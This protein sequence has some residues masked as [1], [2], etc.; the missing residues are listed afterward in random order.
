MAGTAV[1]AKTDYH[2]AVIMEGWLRN[3]QIPN[4]LLK[5]KDEVP[6]NGLA[7]YRLVMYPQQIEP[8]VVLESY[9]A[10]LPSEEGAKAEEVVELWTNNLHSCIR[11]QEP[12]DKEQEEKAKTTIAFK[13]YKST[14]TMLSTS[15]VHLEADCPEVAERWVDALQTTIPAKA[16]RL[17]EL[18]ESPRTWRT[19]L[20]DPFYQKN[21]KTQPVNRADVDGV[22]MEKV[23]TLEAKWVAY[24]T[25]TPRG[26]A[27]PRTKPAES[28][29]SDTPYNV[30][31]MV[32][33]G[34]LCVAVPAATGVIAATHP[35]LVAGVVAATGSAVRSAVGAAAAYMGPPYYYG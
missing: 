5:V 4:G 15:S 31:L 23:G 14:D 18:R 11:W 33:G 6:T 34:T 10:Q 28:E 9:G 12:K 32:A 35:A 27:T 3:G 17:S 21:P 2:G 8:A 25:G 30:G 26:T 19:W 16:A 7:Y 22:E 24:S 1:A 13:V 29:I 20:T